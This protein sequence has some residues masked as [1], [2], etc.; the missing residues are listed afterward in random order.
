MQ[1]CNYLLTWVCCIALFSLWSCNKNNDDPID[2]NPDDTTA[3]AENELT[4]KIVGGPDA[5]NGKTVFFT[6]FFLDET[7]VG[8]VDSING[9]VIEGVALWDNKPAYLKILLP[10]TIAQFYKFEETFPPTYPDVNKYFEI[11]L[12]GALSLQQ[13]AYTNIKITE[14]GAVGGRIKGTINAKLYDYS[15]GFEEIVF[16]N[17]GEFDFLRTQ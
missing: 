7:Y 11:N 1:R 12:N 6:N 9:T 15:Q 17:E 13:I 3:V 10:D 2:T 16:I 14:Y 8:V 5:Y 4:F